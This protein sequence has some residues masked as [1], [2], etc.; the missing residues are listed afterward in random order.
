MRTLNEMELNGRTV[1]IRTGFDVPVDDEGNIKD[2]KRIRISIPTIRKVLEAGASKVILMWHMGRPKDNEERLKT[3]KVAARLSELL[4]EQVAKV[5]D[6]GEKGLPDARIVALENVRFNP[7]EKSKDQAERDEFGK[8]LASLADIYVNDAYSNC[9][10]DQASMTSVPRFIPGCAGLS[11]EKEVQTLSSAVNSPEHPLVTIVGGLKAEKLDALSSLIGKSDHILVG[12][13][14]AFLLLKAQG[15]DVGSSK[16]DEEGL[17]QSA[18]DLKRLADDPKVILPTDCVVADAFSDDAQAKTVPVDAIED[19][20][21]ALDIGPVTTE[22]YKQVLDSARTVLWFGPIGVFEMEKF[23]AGTREIAQKLASLDAVTIIGGGDSSNAVDSLGLD[24]KMT[25][26]STG[27]GASLTLA[28]G[29]EL[30]AVKALESH[31]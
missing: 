28:Q 8:Q 16:I 30:V 13:A 7:Q 27:G 15:K 18:E 22:R 3:G 20:W 23:S 24:E 14:L 19:G 2:D 21:M 9:H 25:L 26:V 12:G 5:D 17:E 29:K 11:V 4:E 6:W 10:H 1:L 31:D